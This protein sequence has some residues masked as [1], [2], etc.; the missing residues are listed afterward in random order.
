MSQHVDTSTIG[1]CFLH[2]RTLGDSYV[3]ARLAVTCV[4]SSISPRRF[5]ARSHFCT[6]GNSETAPKSR[7]SRFVY[8]RTDAGL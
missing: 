2:T 5:S 6:G 8:T 3:L 7:S 1:C 4:G